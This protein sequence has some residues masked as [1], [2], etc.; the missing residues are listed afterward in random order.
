M[1]NANKKMSK[2]TFLR[3]C[4]SGSLAGIAIA[5]I[6]AQFFGI[7]TSHAKDLIGGAVGAG[8]VVAFKLAHLI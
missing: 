6:I 7:D 5:G 1:K 2:L 4:L 3:L 8:A